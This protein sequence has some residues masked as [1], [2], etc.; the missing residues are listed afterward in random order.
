MSNKGDSIID[1]YAVSI[2]GDF[3][4]DLYAMSSIKTVS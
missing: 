3:I 4:R 1:L 2:I